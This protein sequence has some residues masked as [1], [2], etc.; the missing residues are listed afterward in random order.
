MNQTPADQARARKLANYDRQIGQLQRKLDKLIQH[1]ARF[2]AEWGALGEAAH[3]PDEFSPLRAVEAWLIEHGVKPAVFGRRYFN[4]PRFV[5]DLRNGR[6]LNDLNR[7][8]VRHIT[9]KPPAEA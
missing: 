7:R 8:K 4:D 1:R 3:L 6:K 5:F 9:S 2:V